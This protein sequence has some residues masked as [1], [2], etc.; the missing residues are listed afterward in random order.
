MT[1]RIRRRADR[2]KSRDPA[3]TPVPRYARAIE[4][5]AVPPDWH[6]A[7]PDFVGVGAQR[8]GTSWWYRFALD[9]H[10]RVARADG[11]PKEL[12]FFDRFWQEAV[13]E[14]LASTYAA[15]FPRPEGALAGEW[16]PRYMHDPW[17]LPL[18]KRA[19]PETR[20]L[21]MLRDPIDRYLSGIAREVR[22]AKRDDRVLA[23][24]Y[25]SDQIAR[26]AY[27]Q[28]LTQLIDLFGRERVLVLQYERCAAEPIAELERTC[29]FL[30]IEAPS[31][32]PSEL[33]SRRRDPAAK[34][35]LPEAFYRGLVERLHDDA[36]AT[37]E[38]CPELDPGLWPTV[39][40]A[41]E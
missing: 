16:T 20:I 10:P 41:P 30:G 2:R 33:T 3:P 15:Q 24:A 32:H 40:G 22:L 34:P 14:D 13:A 37:A 35:E 38:L 18:L 31:E 25:V 23:M 4:P 29:R 19:A 7:P 9:A 28:P 17:T 12:H 39:A 11:Q 1:L 26:S 21:V 8:A 27:Q 36:A 5:P 6:T